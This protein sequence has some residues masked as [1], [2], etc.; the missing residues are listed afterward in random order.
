MKQLVDKEIVIVAGPSASGKS[1]LLKQLMTKKTNIF[2]D[3]IYREL[4]IDPQKPRSCIAIGALAKLKKKKFE[5]SNK[6]KKDIIF[7]HFDTTSRRQK[8]KRKIL[9]SIAKNCKSMK[10]LTIHTDFETWRSRMERRVESHSE[11]IPLNNALEIYNLS[12]YIPFFAKRRYN[13]SYRNWDLL[14]KDIKL[15]AQLSLKNDEIPFKS[16]S[17]FYN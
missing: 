4:N 2:K 12:K 6:L 3:T 9:L 10:T 13:L 8:K 1:H 16:K 5:H 14:I 7:I 15:D 11:K 17:K